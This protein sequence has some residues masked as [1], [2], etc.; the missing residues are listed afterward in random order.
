MEDVFADGYGLTIGSG[1]MATVPIGLEGR[2]SS[3][4]SMILRW[5]GIVQPEPEDDEGPRGDDV[6]DVGG[7]GSTDSDG[8]SAGS[9]IALPKA[10]PRPTLPSASEEDRKR[11]LKIIMQVTKRLGVCAAGGA[12][13]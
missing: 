13:A 8:D 5:Y 6:S 9:V 10:I 11:G 4:R 12:A 3:L 2:I 1:F 7:S